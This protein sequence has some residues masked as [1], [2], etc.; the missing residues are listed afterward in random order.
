MAVKLRLQRKGRKKAPFYHIVVAD[1][2]SPRDGRFIERLGT[3]NPMTK[4][5]TIL[6]DGD[7]AYDWLMKG[8]QPTD[9]VNAILKFKGILYKKHLMRGVKKGAMTLEQAMEKFETFINSKDNKLAIRVEETK[10]EK[11]EKHQFIFGTPKA[12][13]EKIVEAPVVEE[14]PAEDVAEVATEEVVNEVVADVTSEAVAEEVVVAAAPEVV[15]EEVVVEAAPEVVAEE[16][17]PEVIMEQGED[18]EFA[19]L[20]AQEEAAPETPADD[21]VTDET[22]EA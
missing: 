10:K 9:T 20:D 4:P 6:L 8:A 18:A 21:V 22:T 2:R 5:A 13:K 11:L 12:K 14:A 1:A 7:K 3:Y 17:A 19:Q 15:A 16:I